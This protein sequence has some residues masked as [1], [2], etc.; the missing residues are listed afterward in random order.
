MPCSSLGGS[1]RA[2]GRHLLSRNV[3][4]QGRHF[5]L[6]AARKQSPH[7]PRPSHSAPQHPAPA[8]GPGAGPGWLTVRTPWRRRI[9]HTDALTA[10]HQYDGVSSRLVLRD[11][12][13]NR[14]ELDPRILAASP[15][16]WHELATG[17]RH[18]L[19]RGTLRL[20]ADVMERLGY[21]IDDETVQAVLRASGLS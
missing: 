13:G 18:S 17:V 3:N 1:L 6:G 10:V 7:G 4:G 9:V 20:G 2:R 19:E 11:T 16:L 14:L 21:H 12:F 15:L 8:L 5:P